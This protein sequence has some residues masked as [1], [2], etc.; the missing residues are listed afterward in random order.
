VQPP[1][2]QQWRLLLQQSWLPL[3]AV[4]PPQQLPWLQL[5]QLLPLLLFAEL[6]Q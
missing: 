3:L 2:E 5:L 1:H 4:L 6:Q